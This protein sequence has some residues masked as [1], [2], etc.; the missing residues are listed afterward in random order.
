MDNNFIQFTNTLGITFK[1]Y[2][3]SS[4][5][6]TVNINNFNLI[7]NDIY[8]NTYKYNGNLFKD[9]VIE[10]WDTKRP[11]IPK[12]KTVC[13][14]NLCYQEL[15]IGNYG[16]LTSYWKN[17]IQLNNN[18]LKSLSNMSNALSHEVGHY[19]AGKSGFDDLNNPLRIQYDK[20]RS[21]HVTPDTSIGEMIEIGRAH[22]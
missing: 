9:M 1:I 13:N 4:V 7:V 15:G 14:S 3:F 19:K 11:D 16:G 8:E 22:V 2:Y 18:V 6:D 10:I 12:T 17:L 20:M 5:E 21:I